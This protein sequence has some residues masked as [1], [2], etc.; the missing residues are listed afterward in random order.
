M[1]T[2]RER[3][4]RVVL[5]TTLFLFAAC[6]GETPT[7]PPPGGGAPPGGG[8]PPASGVTINLATSNANPLVDS[9]VVVTATVTQ[10]GAQVPNGTAVEFVTTNGTLDGGGTSIIKTTTNGVAT[11]ILSSGTAGSSRVTAT[12]NNVSQA[13]TV[14]F[15]PRPTTEP[16]PNTS[17][18]ITSIT[19]AVGKPAGG[20]TI[21]ITG[22]N[23][24]GPIRVLFDLGGAMPVEAFVIGH[25]GSLIEVVTPAVNLGAGQQLEARI[26][27]ITEAGTASEERVD[28]A[29]AFTFRN[30][31]L[32]PIISTASPNSG[33]IAGGTIVTLFGEGF[34][35]PVQVLFGSAEARIIDVK[36]AQIIVEAPT[37]RD[38]NPNGSGTVTGPINVI[39]RNI[40][41]Q[42]EATLTGGFRYVAA[43]QITS[44]APVSGPATGGTVVVIDGT[45]FVS[46]VDVT[47]AGQRARV[48]DASSGTRL[49]VQT[50]P[51]PISCSGASGAVIVTNVANGDSDT[52]GDAANEVNFVYHAVSPFFTALV[53]TGGGTPVPGSSLT[54]TIRDPGVGPLGQADIRFEIAGRT[55]IPSPSLITT[56]SGSQQFT[57]ALP[58]T[59]FEFPTESCV[60]GLGTGTRLGP[61]EAQLLFRNLSTG[62][63]DTATITVNPPGANSCVVPPPQATVS[64]AGCVIAGSS[65]V[66]SP[67]APQTITFTNGAPAGGQTLTVQVIS[68]TNPGEFNVAP[69]NQSIPAGGSQGFS[70][71]FTPSA[72]GAR[73]GSVTFATND[74]ARPQITV[75]MTGTGTAP[76]P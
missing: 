5:L 21:R 54:A 59:G 28:R 68:N 13:A 37:A 49:V 67:A 35:Y 51:L 14:T 38:T 33:P 72:T 3:S 10:N 42:T 60:T 4:I 58:T 20:E 73:S 31:R 9:T 25:T 18:T 32:T 71:T 39:V 50:E 53:A 12:V 69:A 30:E 70:V 61:V 22:T 2:F 34:Q 66:A 65:E 45:G 16:Q 55:L 27:V 6:K 47:V 43:M 75:C 19:P 57:M 23:F 40:N 1:K 24:R 74:P 63:T 44:V 76:A 52:Y 48:L 8:T 29:A 36:Y 41:S 46:P 62:C 56:G 17:P 26:I 64:P 7:A 11:V 15:Q